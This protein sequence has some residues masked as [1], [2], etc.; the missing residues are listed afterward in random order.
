[1][2]VARPDFDPELKAGLAVVGGMFPPTITPGLVEFMRTSYASHPLD[3]ELADRGIAR[4]DVIVEGHCG[5]PIEVSVLRP[6]GTPTS[7]PAAS[8]TPSPRPPRR[9]GRSRRAPPPSSGWPAS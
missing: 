7:R 5:D 9:A 1:M 3:D 6:P 8:S 2:A 4:T